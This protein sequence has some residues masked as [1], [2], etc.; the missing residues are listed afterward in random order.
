M[1]KIAVLSKSDTYTKN[2]IRQLKQS[3]IVADAKIEEFNNGKD[4]VNNYQ[5]GEWNLILIDENIEPDILWV[6][7]HL[8]KKD[9]HVWLIGM[10]VLRNDALIEEFI[11][12]PR[13][14]FLLKLDDNR[15]LFEEIFD[16]ED[17]VQSQVQQAVTNQRKKKILVVD[18]FENTL[19][20]VKFTLEHADYEV[21]TAKNGFEALEQIRKNPDIDLMIVDLNMPKMNGFQL[22]ENIRKENLLPGVPIL[23]LTTDI[24]QKKRERAKQLK[25]TG[26][27]Q[28]PYKLEDFL[29]IIQRALK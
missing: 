18:D 9:S 16:S 17:Q 7:R 19:F 29:E 4:F 21:V 5:P 27:I 28:K 23:I 3:E 1:I 2:V 6:E 22:I 25:V 10:S 13:T 24:D 12:L 26:W 14:S 20:V 8:R 15:K 11:K